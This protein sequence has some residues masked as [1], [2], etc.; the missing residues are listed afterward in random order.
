MPLTVNIRACQSQKKP[1]RCREFVLLLLR[2]EVKKENLQ[3]KDQ[4]KEDQ[5]KEDQQKEED[6]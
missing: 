1:K 5:Q 4:E 6:K 2:E 3:E